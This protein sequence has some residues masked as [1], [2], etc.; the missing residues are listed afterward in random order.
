MAAAERLGWD[1]ASGRDLWLLAPGDPA[2]WPAAVR[3]PARHAIAI[4]AGPTHALPD[5][6]L[7]ALA[8]T[9]LDAGAIWL[10]VWGPGAE[11]AHALFR[12]AVLIAERSQA[13]ETVVMTAAEGGTLDEALLFAL[14]EARPSAA[15]TDACDALLVV[16]LDAAAAARAR[17]AL[18]APAE[19]MA[20]MTTGG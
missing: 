5:A 4:V 7:H 2:T 18:A 10:V 6:A 12:D 16:A 13:E 15:Y 8:R 19:F 11:R 9:L 3:L 1:E 14:A 17:A 20:R